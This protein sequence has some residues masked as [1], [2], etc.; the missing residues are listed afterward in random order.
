MTGRYALYLTPPPDHPLYELGQ[1]LIGRDAH[2]GGPLA[3]PVFRAIAPALFADVTK[4]PR[5]YGFHATLKAPFRLS[6]GKSAEE[7]HQAAAR[8][9]TAQQS[10]LV[11]KLEIKALDRFIALIPADRCDPLHALA[12]AC[13]TEFD[14]FRA[15]P[16][17]EELARRRE[18]NLSPAQDAMLTKWGYPFVFEQFRPHFSLT[19][20]IEDAK[21][22]EELVTAIRSHIDESVLSDV[23]FD[24]LAIFGQPDGWMPFYETARFPFGA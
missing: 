7:L 20:R 9:A 10:F 21:Q 17:E 2:Y 15:P 19:S 14:H 8:F 3:Q 5:K 13:V 6:D 18:A 23:R 11:P 16:T 4:T 22:L 1:Q 24:S 12:D